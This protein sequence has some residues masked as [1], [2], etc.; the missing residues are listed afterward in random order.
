VA[1]GG[2]GA[3][4]T[5]PAVGQRPD[6]VIGATLAN[7]TGNPV[8]I[9][10]ARLGGGQW[11]RGGGTGRLGYRSFAEWIFGAQR[12][13]SPYAQITIGVPPA[14][15]RQGG[16]AI[17][18]MFG[19]VT[20]RGVQPT[21]ACKFTPDRP[22]RTGETIY[23]CKSERPSTTTKRSVGRGDRVEIFYSR[24]IRHFVLAPAVV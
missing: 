10:G 21:I 6:V 19:N 22:A 7:R 8:Y 24:I 14:G 1:A 16:T 9:S 23:F 18:L 15:D 5:G 17:I 4:L 11:V 20:A 2:L 3:A 13:Q 12:P